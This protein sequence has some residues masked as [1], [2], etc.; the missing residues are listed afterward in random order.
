MSSFCVIHIWKFQQEAEQ[1]PTRQQEIKLKK[2]MGIWRNENYTHYD[3][4]LK[5]IQRYK[6]SHT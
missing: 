5:Q 1:G 2:L 3:K 4:I 6:E